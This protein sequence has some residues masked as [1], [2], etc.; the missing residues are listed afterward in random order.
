M[1]TSIDMTNFSKPQPAEDIRNKTATGDS[2]AKAKLSK[3]TST[4]ALP[5]SNRSKKA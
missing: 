3:G 5:A 4:C 1:A 2:V